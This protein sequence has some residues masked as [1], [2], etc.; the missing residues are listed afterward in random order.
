MTIEYLIPL[1]YVTVVT[2]VSLFF[3]QRIKNARSENLKAA[4]K[5]DIQQKKFEL[6]QQIRDAQIEAQKYNTPDQLVKHSILTRKIIKMQRAANKL[7]QEIKEKGLAAT[8]EEELAKNVGE[9]KRSAS[10][11]KMLV[12][13]ILSFV[14]SRFP[15][16]FN[17]DADKLY[18][19]ELLLGEK[20]EDGTWRFATTF[21]F[22]FLVVRFSTRIATLFGIRA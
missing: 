2:A 21:F 22:S 11:N 17:I 6:D 7:E 12:A 13:G 1:A 5:T 10:N 18:P 16:H 9:I 3:G 4:P 19:I 8:Y 15:V 14:M 20:I